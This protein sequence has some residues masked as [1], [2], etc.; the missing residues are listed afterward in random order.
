MKVHTRM[1]SA[2]LRLDIFDRPRLPQAGGT[3]ARN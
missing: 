1:R 3:S 2:H